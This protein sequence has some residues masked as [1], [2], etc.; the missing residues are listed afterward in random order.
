MRR[1]ATPGEV[2][3]WMREHASLP[4]ERQI[5]CI[6]LLS[7]SV[8]DCP[9]CDQAVRRCDSRGLVR[10]RLVHLRCARTRDLTSEQQDALEYSDHRRTSRRREDA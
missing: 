9:Y 6:K 3:A 2:A 4:R 8:A 7:E 10:A 1:P 5:A